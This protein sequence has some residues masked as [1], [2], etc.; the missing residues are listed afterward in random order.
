M[1]RAAQ[2]ASIFIH[3]ISFSS[4]TCVGFVVGFFNALAIRFGASFLPLCYPLK[5]KRYKAMLGYNWRD[6]C[7][8][9]SRTLGIAIFS[10]K[11]AI[12]D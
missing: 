5:A 11:T 3:T 10:I 4:A 7:G 6:N 9:S 1:A 12:S 2:R 8:F